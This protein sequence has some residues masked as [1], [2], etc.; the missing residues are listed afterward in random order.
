M[1]NDLFTKFSANT[2]NFALTKLRK[3]GNQKKSY[4]KEEGP[5]LEDHICEHKKRLAKI[6]RSIFKCLDGGSQEKRH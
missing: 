2:V 5:F 6:A 1:S 3:S 4:L